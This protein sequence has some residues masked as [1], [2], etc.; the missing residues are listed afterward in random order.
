M[1]TQ[2]LYRKYRPQNFSD[3]SGQ[4]V[5]IKILENSIKK[6]IFS[7]AYIFF[8]PRGTG[9]TSVAKIFA[10]AVNCETDKER[11]C[12]KCESCINSEMGEAVDIIEIDAAS[13]NGIDDIR[14]IKNNIN[15]VPAVLKYKVYIID[16]VHMLTTGAFNALLKT[17]EEPP[18]HALFI[19]ATTELNK[20]PQT[21]LSRCQLIEFKKLSV[22][23]INAR[24]RE[25]AKLEKIEIDERA[26]KEISKNANGGMRDALGILDKAVAYSQDKLI[27]L[28][29][30][31]EITGNILDDDLD[32]LYKNI[33]KKNEIKAFQLIDK[34]F[35]D[36]KDLV[37]I[38]EALI[39]KMRDSLFDENLEQKQK[40][41][42]CSVIKEFNEVI[43]KMKSSN[44]QK[45]L[46]DVFLM[47]IISEE[48]EEEQKEEKYVEAPVIEE[49]KT[50]SEKKTKEPKLK[51]TQKPKKESIKKKVKVKELKEIRVNNCFVGVNKIL[52]ED[53]I[54]NWT[55]LKDYLLD[56]K[57]G[58]NAKLLLSADIAAVSDSHIIL[59]LDYNGSAEEA[60][61]KIEDYESVL[62]K[63]LKKKYKLVFVS[64]KEWENI[65]KEFIENKGKRYKHIE[66]DDIIYEQIENNSEIYDKFTELF[67][68]KNIEIKGE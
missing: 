32:I 35:D 67:G 4:K 34:Y 30:I 18:S 55:V 2:V 22:R 24:L 7:H 52:K 40:T 61:L 33:L 47:G 5:S 57:I 68:D 56:D 38:S 28:E 26:I 44:Y 13:N 45:V 1:E 41:N 17:L 46:L 6:N 65:T 60:N 10:K 8:G 48:L 27:E 58:N 51:K 39:Y 36:G 25:V 9:K 3:V 54:K 62:E 37:I 50:I 21:I 11:P 59:M 23:D 15:L 19:L 29:D 42:I 31:K 12:G 63:A 16:E 14:E 20:V 66:E 53:L 43:E 49:Q 64:T